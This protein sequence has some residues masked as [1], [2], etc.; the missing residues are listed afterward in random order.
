M[1]CFAGAYGA[2]RLFLRAPPLAF[3]A[4][5]TEVHWLDR[6]LSPDWDTWGQA[7][8]GEA[9]CRRWVADRFP[10][11]R[12]VGSVAIAPV[13]SHWLTWGDPTDE[14]GARVSWWRPAEMRPEHTWFRQRGD[15]WEIVQCTEGRAHVH[16]FSH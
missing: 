11:L 6:D 3:P 10:E 2:Y 9:S 1:A 13:E 4:D 8:L 5:A 12:P 7:T 15:V 16:L 14:R